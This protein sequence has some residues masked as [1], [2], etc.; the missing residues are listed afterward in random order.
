MWGHS[1]RTEEW[2]SRLLRRVAQGFAAVTIAVAL[3]AL[4][5]WATGRLIPASLRQDFIPMS[6]ATALVFVLL[7]GALLVGCRHP[8]PRRAR[9]LSGAG[10]TLV[11]LVGLLVLAQYL[12]GTD[13]G[14][15]HWLSRSAETFGQVPIGRLSPLTAGAFVVASLALLVLLEA[16]TTWRPAH[17][18]AAS[19]AVGVMVVG[20]L[21]LL[22]YW[23]RTAF[24]FGGGVIPMALPTA[25]AFV[26]L[27]AGLLAGA[28]SPVLTWRA[29]ASLAVGFGVGLAASVSL[30]VLITS[31]DQGRVRGE[32]DRKAEVLALA[33][34]AG[35]KDAVEELRNVGALFALSDSVDRRSFRTF[36]SRSWNASRVSDRSRGPRLSRTANGPAQRPR[37]NAR[38]FESIASRSGILTGG[39]GRPADAPSTHQWSTSSHWR[40]AR[41]LWGSMCCPTLCGGR[42]WR[43]HGIS[44][45]PLRRSQPPR[46]PGHRGT[47]GC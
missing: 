22:G 24:V 45:G 32:F 43:K 15:E 44:D 19:A 3:L 26:F 42:R 31:Q 7:G 34:R 4:G 6:L 1:R 13:L 28:R 30:F 36:V 27:G 18:V 39:S 14:F 23:N 25:A 40:C 37:C 9:W 21:V 17:D 38:V 33:F 29:V 2:V 20:V 11:L 47:A 35:V 5:G 16:P 12:T 8:A 10:A 46:R 41:L